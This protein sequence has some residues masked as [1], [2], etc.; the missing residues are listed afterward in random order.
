MSD[1]N[2]SLKESAGYFGRLE[3]S[4]EIPLFGCRMRF[5]VKG[6]DEIYARRCAE[7]FEN[8]TA[9]NLAEHTALYSCLEALVIY[10]A[11][12]LDEH[13]G[14]FDLGDLEFDEDSTVGDLLELITP[15]EL[16]FER[17]DYVSEEDCPIAYSIKFSFDPV[18][19]EVMEIAL[20][21]DVPVYAGEVCGAGAWNDKLLKKRYNYLN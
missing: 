2:Y 1:K 4:V 8:L 7:H 3:G 6:D 19:D 18:P 11:D 5:Y 20:H 9:A 17:S 13:S 10:V 14:E 12:M 21:G 16:A 15:T